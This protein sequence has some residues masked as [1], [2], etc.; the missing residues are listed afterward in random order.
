MILSFISLGIYQM[1]TETYRLRDS[2][3]AEGEFYNSIRMSMDIVQRDVAS[4]YS[5][6]IVAAPTR[7]QPLAHGS[8][9]APC[10]RPIPM[11]SR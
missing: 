4:M 6:I 7:G 5:P 11:T 2:L 1:T 10:R 3:A 9:T 8:A